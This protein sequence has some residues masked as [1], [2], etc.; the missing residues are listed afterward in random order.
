MIFIKRLCL[1]IFVILFALI[2]SEILCRVFFNPPEKIIVLTD[3]NFNSSKKSEYKNLELKDSP[4][5]F[6][7]YV[8]T[9]TGRRLRPNTDIIIKKHNLSNREIK[10]KI[11][12]LGYRNTEISKTK[13]K[14]RILFLGDSITFADY[15]D[16]YETFVRLTEKFL[17][18]KYNINVE[19]INAGVGSIGLKNELAILKE[20]GISTNPDIVIIDFYLNDFERSPGVKIPVLPKF[21][22][23][24]Y[25]AQFLNNAILK[26]KIQLFNNNY[27]FDTSRET[28]IWR[29]DAKK[30]IEKLNNN[31]NEFSEFKKQTENY[32][33]DWALAWSDLAWQKIIPIFEEFKRLAKLNNFKLFVIMFPAK[34]QLEFQT[35]DL[36]YPQRQL[37]KICQ[38]LEIQKL[39]L[40]Q[41][42]KK[43]MNEKIYKTSD[44]FLD[45]CHHT[46]L[47]SK[48]T[49]ELISEFLA[50][51]INN[52]YLNK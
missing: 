52:A 18:E 38:D 10:I 44:L 45:Q 32:S 29:D 50:K 20:T 8:E 42:Y 26:I 35:L 47:G 4:E 41:A 39:D 16:E 28:L 22:K 3:N 9:N 25:L 21:L 36:E 1:L 23:R 24:S 14:P 37:Q 6:G 11:N 43:I 51:N 46:A 34:Q 7:L 31:T 13:T 2:I 15:L 40:L 5:N 48:I 33:V 30:N 12:S 19:T 27:L 17:S 49:A